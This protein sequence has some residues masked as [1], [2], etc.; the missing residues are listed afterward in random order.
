MDNDHVLDTYFAPIL[1][2]DDALIENLLFHELYETAKDGVIELYEFAS[3]IAILNKYPVDT[4]NNVEVDYGK[5]KVPM[6]IVTLLENVDK[7]DKGL[8][9]ID[10]QKSSS[11]VVQAFKSI[12]ASFEK[13]GWITKSEFMNFLREYRDHV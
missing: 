9:G 11:E 5:Y 10:I 3:I 1:N 7:F 8:L 13:D 6:Y 4:N 2:L 12:D